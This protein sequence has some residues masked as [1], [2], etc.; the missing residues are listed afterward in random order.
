[1]NLQIMLEHVRRIFPQ[2]DRNYPGIEGLTTEERRR[3]MV[4]H[5]HL[6]LSKQTGALAALIERGDHTDGDMRPIDVP[7]AMREIVAK[8]LINALM[9]AEVTGVGA[10]EV[11]AE[12]HARFGLDP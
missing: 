8:T 10:D 4:R 9:L 11:E 5:A 12:L 7:R 2:D 1:M 3:F 6:H